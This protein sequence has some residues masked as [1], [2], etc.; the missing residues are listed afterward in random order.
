MSFSIILFMNLFFMIIL[1]GGQNLEWRD[2]EQ[3]VF[4]N[5]EIANIKIKKD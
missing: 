5:F 2:V 1:G 3:P 4:R